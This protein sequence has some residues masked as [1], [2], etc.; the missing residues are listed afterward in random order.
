MAVNEGRTFDANDQV[1]K[2]QVSPPMIQVI[3]GGL[4]GFYL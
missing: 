1:Y 4:L 2:L 3:V